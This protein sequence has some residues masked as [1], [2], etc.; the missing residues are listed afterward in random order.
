M[1][2]VEEQAETGE[3]EVVGTAV[4]A[5]AMAETVEAAEAMGM[6]AAV[7]AVVWDTVETAARRPEI[8]IEEQPEQSEQDLE[9]PEATVQAVAA[10][11]EDAAV[12]GGAEGASGA[13]IGAQSKI[14]DPG[15]LQYSTL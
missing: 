14:F 6:E 3:A 13:E 7:E 8:A 11:G 10:E 9:V 15:K 2:Q 4:E 5:A 12:I 1:S